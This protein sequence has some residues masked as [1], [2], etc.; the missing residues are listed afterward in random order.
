MEQK[1]IEAQRDPSAP[2]QFPAPSPIPE[3]IFIKHLLSAGIWESE[4]KQKPT[5]SLPEWTCEATMTESHR[6]AF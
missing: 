1:L 6:L 5:Q 3:Y 2:T 4:D